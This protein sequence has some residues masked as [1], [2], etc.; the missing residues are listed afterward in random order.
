M[1]KPRPLLLCG[2]LLASL[3]SAKPSKPTVVISAISDFAVTGLQSPRYWL[4]YAY[5]EVLTRRL[6]LAQNLLVIEPLKAR[7]VPLTTS[8][9]S[10]EEL[11]ARSTAL[12]GELS[13]PFVVTGLIEDRGDTLNITCLVTAAENDVHWTLNEE[14]PY[15]SLWQPQAD[16]IVRRFLPNMGLRM[17]PDEVNALVEWQPDIEP[18]LLQ[19]VGEGWRAYAPN[20]P[21]DAFKMWRQAVALDPRCDLAAEALASAGYLYRRRLLENAL[22]YYQRRLADSPE[23]PMVN[24]HL[25]QIYADNAEWRRAEFHFTQA[26]AGDQ[27]FL[28]AYLGRLTALIEQRRYQDAI[29][30]ALGTLQLFPGHPKVMHNLAVAYYHNGNI[31]EARDIWTRILKDHPDDQLAKDMLAQYGG[32]A[33]QPLG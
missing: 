19:L 12:L 24:Y 17:T 10:I 4:G 8:P 7:Q 11:Q 15:E 23:D 26:M 29:A 1:A 25:G 16:I 21:E 22:A 18:K 20:E 32:E 33:V 9:R 28:D 5:A 3:A 30:T 13:V 27:S 14:V 31:A 2:L 6:R